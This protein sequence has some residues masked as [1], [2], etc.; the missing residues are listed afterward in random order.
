MNQPGDQILAALFCLFLIFLYL[1]PTVTASSRYHRNT[2]PIFLT[3]LFFGWSI[4]GWLIA[5]IWSFSDNVRPSN[6]S[7]KP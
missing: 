4:L 6:K 5:L 3:N 1:L 7:L 2:G